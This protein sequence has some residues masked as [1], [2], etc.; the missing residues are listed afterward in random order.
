MIRRITGRL[1]GVELAQTCAADVELDSGL[2]YEVLL[3]RYLA[4]RLAAAGAGRSVTLH[5]R[6]YLEA[7]G[8]GTSFVP[9]LIG[10]E[11]RRDRQFFEL[12]T[13]VKGLGARKSLRCMTLE[14]ATIAAAIAAKD[15]KALQQLPE[16]GKRLAETIVA[17]LH[18]KVDSHL[19]PEDEAR[20]SAAANGFIEHKPRPRA[21]EEAIETLEALGES[22]A[23]A[24]RMVD[25]VLAQTEPES[26]Q[27]PDEI[28]AAALGARQPQV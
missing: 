26:L 16:I 4:E 23:D 9:R 22:R 7:V 24:E 1:E 20:L 28:V 25:R 13:S 11:A 21:I 15:T 10:F 5:T 2:V 18:G 17:E 14:P 3:P 19:S 27:T 12:F 6:A 8:Q